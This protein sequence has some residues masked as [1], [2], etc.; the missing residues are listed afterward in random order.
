MLVWAGCPDP[1]TLNPVLCQN[2]T[3]RKSGCSA[4]VVAEQPAQPYPASDGAFARVG[5]RRRGLDK[6]VAEPLMIPFTMVVLGV[7]GEHVPKV[8]LSKRDYAG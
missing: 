4:V 6:P 5:V 8:P 1:L 2:S 7:L 3:A